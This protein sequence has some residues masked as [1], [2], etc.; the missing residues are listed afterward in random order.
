MPH[1][2]GKQGQYLAF[3]DY[4]TKV[5]RRPPAET[6]IQYFF[7]VT[8]PT[9]HQMILT[10]EK[11]GFVSREPGKARTVKVLLSPDQLPNLE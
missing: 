8:P 6:D 9:V 11:L 4:Y 5:N 2:T 10:L 1:Y 3:I 7:N